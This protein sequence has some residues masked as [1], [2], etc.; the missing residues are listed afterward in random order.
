M[1]QLKINEL[2]QWMAKNEADLVYISDPGHIAYFSGYASEP[3]E[4]VL[5]LFI[6]LEKDPFLFTPALEIDDAKNSGWGYD[7]VGY[8]D[9]EEPWE[10]IIREIKQR[11]D[12][13]KKLALEKSCLTLDRFEALTAGFTQTDFSIDVTPVVQRLQLIKTEAEINTLLEAGTWADVAFEIGFKAIQAGAAEQEIVAEIEYQ[14][15]RQGVSAMSFDTIVLTGANAASPHGVPGAS[16]I[17][18]NELVLFDLGVV[19]KGYC[20]DA[21]RTVAYKEPTAFQKEIHQLV[22]T[23][24]LEAQKAV[25]PSVTAAELDQ[26]ARNVITEA[27]YG[28]YFN[29]RLGHGIGTT[30]HEFPSLVAGNDLVIEEGMCF[31]L[32]PGIYIP[33]QVGV[34]IEDCVYVTK[35]GCLPFTKTA[36]ELLIIE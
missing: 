31:S 17:A 15:K 11:Y 1:N 27:G 29:H 9:S 30:V 2:R 33:N 3:H 28:E 22:L 26:V 12:S 5:A 14:L 18:P 7:V 10:M 34:R 8:L 25:R 19:W 24:Q 4:R 32:E 16:K 21:T 36:K 20:S 13:P 6:P 23:A 35:D